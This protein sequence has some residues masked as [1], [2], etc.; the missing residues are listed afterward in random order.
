MNEPTCATRT[1]RVAFS[2][3]GP[4]LSRPY[5]EVLPSSM[6]ETSWSVGDSRIEEDL[7]RASVT[8][9]VACF[10]TE[11]IQTQMA[12]NAWRWVELA[13]GLYRQRHPFETV[14]FQD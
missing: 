5:V 6:S 4:I 7:T 13:E 1:I 9:P 14:V 12:D 10:P 8:F 11:D 3:M 2:R